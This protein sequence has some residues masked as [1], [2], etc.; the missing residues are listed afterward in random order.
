MSSEGRVS[1]DVCDFYFRTSIWYKLRLV[2]SVTRS[3]Y[4]KQ[5]SSK[6]PLVGTGRLR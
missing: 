5:L 6:G 4:R 2:R 1:F 3:S